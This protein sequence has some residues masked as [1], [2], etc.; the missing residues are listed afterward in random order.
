MLCNYLCINIKTEQLTKKAFISSCVKLDFTQ[1]TKTWLL[2]TSSTDVRGY[3]LFLKERKWEVQVVSGVTD[4]DI[5][6]DSTYKLGFD[7]LKREEY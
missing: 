5:I 4:R 7:K 2:C 3:G 1:V 6:R